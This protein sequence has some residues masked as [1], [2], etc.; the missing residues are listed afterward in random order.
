MSIVDTTA[1]DL[2]TKA[3]VT[4]PAP[5]G[6]VDS[7]PPDGKPAEPA[8]RPVATEL[9][10]TLLEKHNLSTPEEL[11]EYIDNLSAKAGKIGNL[12][13]DE[14]VKAHETLNA[15]HKEWAKQER[16]KQKAAEKPEETIARLEKELE[17]E[18]KRKARA[19]RESQAAQ[20]AREALKTYDN[21]VTAAINSAADFPPEYKP[22][23]KKIMGVDNPVN[24]IDPSDRKIAT[25]LT[26]EFGIPLMQQLEQEVIKRY[27][28]G[29]VA[30]PS[31][32]APSGGEPP[33]NAGN[34]PKTQSE[35]RA[36]AHQLFSKIL[37]GPR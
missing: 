11:A 12:D 20:E 23:L 10:T 14:L 27:L 2:A 36:L 26:K 30:I 24:A 18:E 17:A 16:E 31:V 21:S 8:Q 4:P 33:V 13:P 6:S 32:P 22:F 35:R 34:P 28:A 5:S 15:Y 19:Q 1:V 37:G 29:K 7:T 25:K 3:S 9:V